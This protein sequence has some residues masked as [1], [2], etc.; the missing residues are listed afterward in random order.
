MSLKSNAPATGKAI[1]R[2]HIGKKYVVRDLT[3]AIV[4]FMGTSSS[5]MWSFHTP[6][7][8]YKGNAPK[9]TVEIVKAPN[10]K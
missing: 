8:S 10:H 9:G 1:S 4:I 2:P 3:T 6:D 5:G 7:G